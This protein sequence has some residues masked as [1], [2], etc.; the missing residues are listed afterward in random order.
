MSVEALAS[1]TGCRVN[2]MLTVIDSFSTGVNEKSLKELVENRNVKKI[3]YDSEVRALLHE[4]T[5]TVTASGLWGTGLTGKGI[6]VAVLDTGIYNHPDL[7]GRIAGFVD[8]VRFRRQTYDDNGHGTHV[9]GC[10]ASSGR[11]SRK[12]RGPAPGAGVVGVKVLNRSGSGM[13]ST[14]IQ[15]VQWCIREK[16]RLKIRIMNISL[17]GEAHV[18]YRDDPLCQAVE[19]AWNSGIVVCAAAGNSGPGRGTIDSPGIHPLIITVGASNDRGI[20]DPREN[21]VTGFSSRGPTIDGITKPDLLAPGEK[22][23]SLRP[24]R[25]MVDIQN[26][27]ARVGAW[28]TAL[29]GTS[30]ATSIC[31]GVAAQLLQADRSLTPGQVKELLTQNAARLPN[32]DSNAQGA[33]IVDARKAARSMAKG[34]PE[35]GSLRPGMSSA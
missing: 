21:R 33:G 13:L 31:A 12:Y 28:Y 1:L 2:R 3:W 29:S 35:R 11:R 4:A 34:L 32:E 14:V 15:G 6:V 7:S 25:S 27:E 20:S 23:V 18:S 22:I 16:D 17:G 24:P 26:K 5:A 30:M 9:A 10:I 8:L 19:R